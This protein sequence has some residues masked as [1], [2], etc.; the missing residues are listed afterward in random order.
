[1]FSDTLLR[2]CISRCQD[3]EESVI[4][5]VPQVVKKSQ[6]PTNL[7][8]LLVC[9]CRTQKNIQLVVDS[10]VFLSSAV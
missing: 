3:A 4:E 5:I 2:G 1:M 10:G 9:L 8:G 6:A 7:F